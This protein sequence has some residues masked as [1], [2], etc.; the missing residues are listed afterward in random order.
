VANGLARGAD[1]DIPGEF[2]QER[3]GYFATPWVVRKDSAIGSL[4]DLRRK[5]VATAAVG[6]STDY[7]QDYHTRPSEPAR[8][9]AR[10][11]SC[12]GARQGSVV[13]NVG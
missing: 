6:G 7:L 5:R 12:G 10:C 4:A 13:L 11:Q 3:T 1:I 2:F 8:R 9:L